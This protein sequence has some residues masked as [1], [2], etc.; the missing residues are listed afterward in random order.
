MVGILPSFWESLRTGHDRN[1]EVISTKHLW[2]EGDLAD[3][4]TQA[5]VIPP[6][7]FKESR[8]AAERTFL[9]LP[10]AVPQ[11]SYSKIVQ[12]ADKPF[13]IFVKRL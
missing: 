1:G 12:Q 5:R 4:Q 3:G 13:K 7:V 10:A 6:E 2:G 8:K 9:R 11:V